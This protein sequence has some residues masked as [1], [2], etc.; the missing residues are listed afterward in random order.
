MKNLSTHSGTRCFFDIPGE[1]ALYTVDLVSTA[2]HLPLAYIMGYD[3]YP[4]TTLETKR[5]ILKQATAEG[6]LFLGHDLTS[7][8]CCRGRA[9]GHVRESGLTGPAQV[10]ILPRLAPFFTK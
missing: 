3:L 8:R 6:W 1:R 4:M 7:A 9:E 10:S 5:A 2:A